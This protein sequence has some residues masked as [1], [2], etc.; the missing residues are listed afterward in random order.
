M[1]CIKCGELFEHIHTGHAYIKNPVGLNITCQTFRCKNSITPH[2]YTAIDWCTN[3]EIKKMRKEKQEAID[4]IYG[5]REGLKGNPNAGIGYTKRT[6]LG[7][8]TDEEK[9]IS[10]ETNKL[11]LK[12]LKEKF[13]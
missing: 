2:F 4:Q 13:N 7:E 11:S 10:E 3:A 8:P 12:E 9:K 6:D 5:K 1:A